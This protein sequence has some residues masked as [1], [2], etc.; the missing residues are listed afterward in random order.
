M[1]KSLLP[2]IAFCIIGLLTFGIFLDFKKKWKVVSTFHTIVSN[3]PLQK[4]CLFI[5]PAQLG[6]Q[7]WDL[8]DFAE[9]Q[10]KTNTVSKQISFHVA[11]NKKTHS[12]DKFWLKI[13]GLAR[14]NEMDVDFWYLLSVNS[15]LPE[16]DSDTVIFPRSAVPFFRQQHRYTP[17]PVLLTRAGEVNVETSSGTFKC[18]H[19]FAYLLAP[20]GSRKPLLELWANSSVRPLGIV[21]ARWRD[22]VLEL[23][24][25]QNQPSYEISEIL[26]K[27]IKGSN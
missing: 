17:Y 10:L 25:R 13:E 26:S 12:S 16:S 23:V 27:T 3:A 6:I 9:Y 4:R 19:Y 7:T 15:L 18:Q 11:A 2:L 22:E 14:F 21:R 20:D 24:R 1:R 8:G 5:S